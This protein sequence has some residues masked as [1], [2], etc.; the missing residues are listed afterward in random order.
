MSAHP[1]TSFDSSP[2]TSKYMS[3]ASLP[4]PVRRYG[5]PRRLASHPHYSWAATVPV[6]TGLASTHQKVVPQLSAVFWQTG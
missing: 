6:Q 2:L 4:L 3:A 5:I 1:L